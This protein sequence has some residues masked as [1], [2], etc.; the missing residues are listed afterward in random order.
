MRRAC[1]SVWCLV[2]AWV[3]VTPLCHYLFKYS[4]KKRKRQSGCFLNSGNE[5][6]EN[7]PSAGSHEKEMPHGGMLSPLNLQA[8]IHPRNNCRALTCYGPVFFTGDHQ[9]KVP[10][11]IERGQWRTVHVLPSETLNISPLLPCSW[12]VW[13]GQGLVDIP[14]RVR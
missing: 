14:G 6:D 13:P 1:H 12:G 2:A 10:W 3:E 9:E 11:T 5:N 7:P 8:V 4:D